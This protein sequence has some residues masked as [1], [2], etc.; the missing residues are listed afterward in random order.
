MSPLAFSPVCC[1]DK[2]Q[3]KVIASKVTNAENPVWDLTPYQGPDMAPPGSFWRIIEVGF[4][5]PW[6]YPWYGA[7][8]VDEEG[9]LV[10]L[11]DEF[12]SEY[13]YN[14]YLQ[15]QI[16]CDGYFAYITWPGNCQTLSQRSQF[17]C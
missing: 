15:L 8:C 14:G 17:P 10:G 1:C 11:P 3:P 16:G 7:G 2:C 13:S 5:F 6:S 9:R 12:V 4:C